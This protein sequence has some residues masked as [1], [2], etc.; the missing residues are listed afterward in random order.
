MELV[1]STQHTC[2]CNLVQLNL[3]LRDNVDTRQCIYVTIMDSDK[4][5]ITTPNNKRIAS[6]TL[7]EIKMT[8][9]YILSLESNSLRPL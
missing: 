5:T 6:V 2:T 1:T 8:Y 7:K 3:F 4:N 9:P